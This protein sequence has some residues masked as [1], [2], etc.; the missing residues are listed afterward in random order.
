MMQ[1]AIVSR[2]KQR[3]NAMVWAVSGAAIAVALAAA[4]MFS[5]RGADEPAAETAAAPA[6][7]AEPVDSAAAPAA[8]D[9]ATTT[10]DLDAPGSA[11]ADMGT[12]SIIC[13]P[14]CSE[15]RIGDRSFGPSPVY[16]REIEPGKYVALL[17]REGVTKQVV[18][19][20]TPGG[21]TVKQV[22]MPSVVAPPRPRPVAA[23]P[24]PAGEPPTTAV[25]ETPPPDGPP[26]TP[27]P[28][29]LDTPP[30]P[31]PSETPPPAPPPADKAPSAPRVQEPV[32]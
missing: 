3:S 15:V 17:Y 10:L 20:V 31:P 5:R 21:E 9:T 25:V 6:A 2:P 24:K 32:F 14:I 28:Q 13:E 26:P 11:V 7:T 1:S 18:V 27:Q 19:E 16:K 4:F 22:E 8:D 29:P 23:L 30:P 12:V